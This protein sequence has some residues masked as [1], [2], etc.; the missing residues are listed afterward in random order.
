MTQDWWQRRNERATLQRPWRPLVDIRC[1][2]VLGHQARSD[3]T[4]DVFSTYFHGLTP[5]KI[6]VTPQ[7]Q[8]RRFLSRVLFVQAQRAGVKAADSQALFPGLWEW[9]QP[10]YQNMCSDA[11]KTLKPADRAAVDFPKNAGYFEAGS[12][13]QSPSP[14]LLAVH[15]AV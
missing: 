13:L 1:Q 2:P 10:G 5:E 15:T 11:V 9:K 7:C 3:R 6:A 4:I 14:C 8:C 12:A